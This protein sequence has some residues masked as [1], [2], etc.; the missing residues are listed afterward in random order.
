MRFAYWE[1]FCFIC[2]ILCFKFFL[3]FSFFFFFCVC[4]KEKERETTNIQIV[5]AFWELARDLRTKNK[6]K[7]IILEEKTE[8]KPKLREK[9][10]IKTRCS[11]CCCQ[12]NSTVN[13]SA[14]WFKVNNRFF[15]FLFSFC[16]SHLEFASHYNNNQ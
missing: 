12:S 11:C 6:I 1:R 14:F 15:S 2:E 16:V 9:R 3:F 13:S 10:G 7:C 5:E 4:E 8:T